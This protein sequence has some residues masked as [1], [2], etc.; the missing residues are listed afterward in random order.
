MKIINKIGLFIVVMLVGF[1]YRRFMDKCEM[2]LIEYCE[3]FYK[4]GLQEDLDR[5]FYEVVSTLDHLHQHKIIH[6]DLKPANIMLIKSSNCEND[7]WTPQII[8]FGIATF[9]NNMVDEKY[10]NMTQIGTHTFMAPEIRKGKR[11]DEKID[12]Y[13]LFITY[14]QCKTYSPD[15][16]SDHWKYAIDHDKIKKNYE[17]LTFSPEKN[18]KAWKELMIAGTDKDPTI[19]PSAFKIKGYLDS[20]FYI[21]PR[22]LRRYISIVVTTIIFLSISMYFLLPVVMTNIK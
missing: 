1:L 21:H 4:D 14:F 7:L 3:T 13:A 17:T 5:L 15:K 12:I 22:K 19:R 8:D 6:R 9:K 2:D 16:G 18:F 20:K 11:Y 10:S